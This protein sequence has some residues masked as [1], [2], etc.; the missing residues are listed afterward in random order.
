MMKM[1]I[2][3]T[4]ILMVGPDLGGQGGISRVMRIYADN[5]IFDANH[6]KYISSTC[7]NAHVK[8]FCL[9][10][11][12]TKF[13]VA[14]MFSQSKVYIHTSSFNSFYRKSIYIFISILLS[15][16]IILHIHP[17][18]FF[19][20]ING[21]HGLKKKFVFYI[22]KRINAYIVLTESMKQRLLKNFPEKFIYTLNNPVDINRM[23]N[24]HSC[25]R[26]SHNIVY[27]GWYIK[28]K[29]VYELVDAIGILRQRGVNVHLDFFGTKEVYKLTH[30]VNHNGL[31]E[32]IDVHGWIDDSEKIDALYRSTM[33]ILPSHTEGLPN[34]ILEA[35]ATNTPIISTF[36][37]GLKD[38]LKDGHNCIIANVGDP[39]DLSNKIQ[40]CLEHPELLRSISKNAYEEAKLHYDISFIGKNFSSIIHELNLL[41]H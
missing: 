6:I 13:S 41:L 24:V 29:G 27:L 23:L 5:G 12:I 20:F 17:T 21:L 19:D 37:G 32:F 39:E 10:L 30:Y 8:L 33:L 26:L 38:I 28:E 18:H 9:L 7:D 34:V 22:L 16:N 4:K 11:S 35:M 14:C 2:P 25:K 1:T 40:M 3:S 36:V 15:K 31:A